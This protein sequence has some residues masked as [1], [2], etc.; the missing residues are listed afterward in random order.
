MTVLA[1]II[2]PTATKINKTRVGIAKLPATL[3]N[4]FPFFIFLPLL[5]ITNIIIRILAM[6]NIFLRLNRIKK[7]SIFMNL[8]L[9]FI[10]PI[11]NR[12]MSFSSPH[13][14]GRLRLLESFLH[15]REDRQL[16][17]PV[18]LL[19]CG[20]VGSFYESSRCL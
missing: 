7:D 10:Q 2:V 20:E 5:I 11:I 8:F 1:L 12:L 6:L 19:S 9:F 4:L 17:E 18:K 16:R 13:S 15:N 3:K 14:N